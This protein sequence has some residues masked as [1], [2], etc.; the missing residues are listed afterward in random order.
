MRTRKLAS[1]LVALLAFA[2]VLSQPAQ[3]QRPVLCLFFGFNP[4]LTLIDG[5]TGKVYTV[6][7]NQHGISPAVVP[8]SGTIMVF[9]FE[10]PYNAYGFGSDMENCIGG[11]IADGRLNSR[12]IAAPVALYLSNQGYEVYG[13]SPV[14]GEGTLLFTVT[15]AEI[16]A[17][18]AGDDGTA[19]V[20]AEGAVGFYMLGNGSCVLNAPDWEGNSYSF[21]WN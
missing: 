5:Y 20:E 2:A 13:I 10:F 14:E 17:A 3:A 18:L 21:S 19:L 11:A 1:V 15:P 4:E 9:G 8:E 6:P 16:A 7:E 12:D